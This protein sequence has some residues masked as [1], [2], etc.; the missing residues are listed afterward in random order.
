MFSGS[1][2]GDLQIK[3]PIDKTVWISNS[4]GSQY[5]KIRRDTVT[6]TNMVATS[7][8]MDGVDLE[9]R[10]NGISL[11]SGV[12]DSN[13]TPETIIPASVNTDKV[14]NPNVDKGGTG[15]VD[16]PDGLWVA[17]AN[18]VDAVAGLAA[19][20]NELTSPGNVKISGVEISPSSVAGKMLTDFPKGLP[21]RID[22]CVKDGLSLDWIASDPDGDLV[23]VYVKYADFATATEV[24][25]EP[26][27]WYTSY[28][29]GY[30]M[31]FVGT[32]RTA[33]PYFDFYADKAGTKPRVKFPIHKGRSYR[34]EMIEGD[35]PYPFMIGDSVSTDSP[36]ALSMTEGR[37]KSVGIA[38]ASNEFIQVTIP[39]N[40]TDTLYYYSPNESQ[41]RD[42]FVIRDADP[43]K[44]LS[45]GSFDISGVSHSNALIVGEDSVGNLSVVFGP[46][47]IE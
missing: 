1:T 19:V 24:R 46:V 10:I 47:S 18:N 32:G 40:F 13:V 26:D 21:P 9:N 22:S 27:D 17:G 29:E 44:E 30:E 42:S 11:K 15:R 35:L 28:D 14:T 41:I 33:E 38:T 45:S 36:L 3:A 20:G 6:T 16:R 12:G 8:E 43:N 25:D 2:T 34:F 39:E 23:A 5:M 37:S 31:V 7:V 4:D